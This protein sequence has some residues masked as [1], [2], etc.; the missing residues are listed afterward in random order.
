M[1]T[2]SMYTFLTFNIFISFMILL[3]CHFHFHYYFSHF[4]H[5]VHNL[6]AFNRIHTV[7]SLEILP[8]FEIQ[9]LA[10][11]IFFFD[12]FIDLLR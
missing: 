9:Q 12:P 2:T 11:I 1:S 8:Q 6:I 3:G 7:V 10:W 5:A 4:L